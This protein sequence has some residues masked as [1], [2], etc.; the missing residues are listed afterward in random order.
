MSIPRKP[1]QPRKPQAGR[2]ALL[3]FA[4]LPGLAFGASCTD[5]E[6]IPNGAI[7]H[8]TPENLPAPGGPTIGADTVLAQVVDPQRAAEWAAARRGLLDAEVV[9]SIGSYDGPDI[10]GIVGD[11]AV[12]EEGNVYIQDNTTD[13][14]L[15]YS[16]SGELLHRVGGSG[17]GPGEFR[18]IRRFDRLPD[19][20]LVVAHRGGPVTV[21][22][23]GT[24]RYEYAGTLLSDRAAQPPDVVDMC[25]LG[26]R[27]FL[28][29]TNL[30]A[31]AHVVHEVAAD[32]GEMV[33]SFADGYRSD[34]ASDRVDRSRGRIA[35][36]ESPPSLLWGLYYFPI[37]EAYRPDNTL[38]WAA[39][40]EDFV[41]GPVYQN[42][43][44]SP[45][46]HP[47]GPP[48]EYITNAHALPPGFVVLQTLL[49]ERPAPGEEWQM[50]RRRT[51]LVD[52][53]TGNGGLVSDDLP[54]IAWIGDSSFI[55]VP[56][57]PYPKVE[58]RAIKEKQH[59]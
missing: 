6:G 41:Q 31:G 42:E 46:V 19:G 32:R 47:R 37:V 25:A 55:T 53:E 49:Y 10:L 9:T 20:R 52:R 1:S 45:T 3:L 40:I 36:G 23:L 7:R 50:T 56:A 59:G 34:F 15:V 5:D 58:V 27:V 2:R 22:A 38:L 21:M 30:D 48:S 35:C 28:H 51:Y 43:A 33:A 13:E 16:A 11:A 4:A 8:P 26:D 18:G 17:D 14:L 54:W 12:D 24:E 29:A 57:E 39:L 44:A